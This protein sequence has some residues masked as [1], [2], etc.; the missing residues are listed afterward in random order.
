MNRATALSLTFLLSLIL[1]VA[2][3]PRHATAGSNGIQSPASGA[4][5]R[6]QIDVRGTADDGRFA[7]WQ[8]DLLTE[9]DVNRA[10]FIALGEQPASQPTTLAALDTT[11]FPDGGYSLRLRV[12]RSDGN[13]DEYVTPI[14]VANHS[15]APAPAQAANVP[16]RLPARTRADYLGIPKATP[17]GRPILY[18]TFDDGPNPVLTPKIVDLLDRYDAKA[19][20]FVV[21]AHLNRSPA[22]LLPVA[23]GGHTIANHTWSHRSLVGLGAEGVASQLNRTADLVQETVREVLPGGAAIRYLRPP[24]GARNAIVDQQAADLGYRIVTWDIDPKD[25]QRPGEAAIA[26]AV[27]NRAFPGAIVVMHDGGGGSQ[28]TVAALE[29]ILE[30]LSDEGYEFHALP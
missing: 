30:T 6:G 24:Y 7:K 5:V 3:L 11:R 21:G 26:S 14:T 9:D 22:A 23:E 27:I 2:W 13:Y 12:V 8:L 19:T 10:T 20:F 1:S 4:S 28:Q 18:L 25:W 17:D 15:A 29:T 16:A